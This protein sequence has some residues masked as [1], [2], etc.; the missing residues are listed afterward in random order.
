MFSNTLLLPLSSIRSNIFSITRGTI[1]VSNDAKEFSKEDFKTA[2]DIYLNYGADPVVP[3]DK[4]KAHKL[5]ANSIAKG[6][7]VAILRDSKENKVTG[8]IIATEV[9]HPYSSAKILQQSFYVSSYHGIKA[10]HALL[11]AHEILLMYAKAKHF[12]HVLSAC[13]HMDDSQQLCRLLEKRGWCV[14][15]YLAYFKLGEEI[16]WQQ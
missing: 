16:S 1:T 7:F 4:N 10:A 9:D 8:A 11:L 5:I 12:S 6:E 15:G 2:T 3:V 14:K 13:S